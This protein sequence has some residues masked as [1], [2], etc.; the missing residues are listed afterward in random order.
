MN[1]NFPIANGSLVT[2]GDDCLPRTTPIFNLYQRGLIVRQSSLN[3][4]AKSFI[5]CRS[6]SF[7]RSNRGRND[8]PALSCS[9]DSFLNVVNRISI[10]R[11]VGLER[12]P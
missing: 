12:V 8:L 9:L 1:L 11:E 6:M 3:G 2:S 7:D 4:F 5:P 10:L